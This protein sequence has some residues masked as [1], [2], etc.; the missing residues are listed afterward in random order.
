VFWEKTQE[1]G[2]VGKGIERGGT[3]KKGKSFTRPHDLQIK[4]EGRG[5]CYRGR[6]QV[7]W[8]KRNR[9]SVM[10]RREGNVGEI[11]R[12]GETFAG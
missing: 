11:I 8:R 10:E 9:G 6:T 5:E 2:D 12:R 4:G 3:E 7:I 1:G